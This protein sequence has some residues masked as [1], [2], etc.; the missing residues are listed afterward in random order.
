MRQKQTQTSIKCTFK[1]RG[2]WFQLFLCF[3][4]V[5]HCAHAASGNVRDIVS[6][7]TLQKEQFHFRL[8]ILLRFL[9]TLVVPDLSLQQQTTL[10][11][12]LA[13]VK[14]NKINHR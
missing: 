4:L 13:K 5:F 6:N 11:A 8:L 10:F 7:N 3:F 2:N 12:V 14:V 9:L 1:H